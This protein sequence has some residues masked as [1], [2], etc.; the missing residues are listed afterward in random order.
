MKGFGTARKARRRPCSV[1]REAWSRRTSRAVR[2][3]RSG[4]FR[5]PLAS[6]DRMKV[7]HD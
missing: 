3:D 1:G 2:R 6:A 5:T 7:H 4:A